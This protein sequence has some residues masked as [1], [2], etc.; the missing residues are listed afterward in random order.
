MTDPKNIRHIKPRLGFYNA[1]GCERDV[2][3]MLVSME[4]RKS[5]NQPTGSF[6]WTLYPEMHPGMHGS[7][8]YAMSWLQERMQP[9]DVV[10]IAFTSEQPYFLGL[11]DSISEQKTVAQNGQLARFINIQGRDFGKLLEEDTFLNIDINAMQM[12]AWVLDNPE[13]D[14]LG[15][16]RTNLEAMRTVIKA[17]STGYI[18][19]RFAGVRNPKE[20]VYDLF[21]AML[22]IRCQVRCSDNMSKS[23]Y[24]FVKLDIRPRP[25]SVMLKYPLGS[26]PSNFWA[27]IKAIFESEF[28]EIYGDT[29]ESFTDENGIT[30]KGPF[31]VVKV[32]PKPWD[33]NKDFLRGV[34]VDSD[35]DTWLHSWESHKTF[36]DTKKHA[37]EITTATKFSKGQ[38]DRDVVTAYK[39]Q[40]YLGA[41]AFPFMMPDLFQLPKYG[42]KLAGSQLKLAD[43]KYL[44]QDYDNNA[45]L[46]DHVGSER[47]IPDAGGCT[48]PATQIERLF[49]WFHYNPVLYSG[50]VSIPANDRIRVGDISSHPHEEMPKVEPDK[51]N[52]G[53][54]GYITDVSQRY[55]LGHDETTFNFIRGHNQAMLD[56]FDTYT[57][58]DKMRTVKRELYKHMAIEADKITNK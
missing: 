48:R 34:R 49:N 14:S 16:D 3:K 30:Q 4:T 28:Y 44:N 22:M 27:A 55:V 38:S 2:E 8:E 7:F 33:K 19:S 5:I 20:L 35:I 24:D 39:V 10:D 37:H 57:N 53:M 12:L 41:T 52:L 13:L 23:F 29:C 54:E 6:Q 46:G 47:L 56:F 31:Y 15:I 43:S 1:K 17:G 40:G 26:N 51:P 45:K 9:Q 11:I 18:E 58:V 36:L 50:A 21:K 25:D 42:F 32:Y